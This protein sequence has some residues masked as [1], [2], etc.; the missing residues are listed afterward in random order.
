MNLTLI[1]HTINLTHNRKMFIY[2]LLLYYKFCVVSVF[3]EGVHLQV[4][5]LKQ[6]NFVFFLNFF[7]NTST[8]TLLNSPK[9]CT[10]WSDNSNFFCK[11]SIVFKNRFL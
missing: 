7:L 3:S 8:E 9:K 10:Y 6:I 4:N 5:I 2:Q 11:I 1:T